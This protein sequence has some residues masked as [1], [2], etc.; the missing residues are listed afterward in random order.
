M[1]LGK[2]IPG[3]MVS[4]E[5]ED[6]LHRSIQ[7]DKH[8]YLFWL[9]YV[10]CHRYR[11]SLHVLIAL[12]K[13]GR[14]G[15]RDQSVVVDIWNRNRRDLT[16]GNIRLISGKANAF[17]NPRTDHCGVSW[18]SHKKKWRTRV[19]M[20]GRTVYLGHYE[21]EPDAWA[22]VDSF[23]DT[24]EFRHWLK[25]LFTDLGMVDSPEHGKNSGE[26]MFTESQ[27]LGARTG[28]L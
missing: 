6:L 26:L 17:N 22:A 27:A 20:D 19:T 10:D 4:P 12:R 18:D 5:D 28:I 24:F 8:D 11:L 13:Y 7:I 3:F 23:K 2:D 1:P 14:A 21:N 15:K 9:W 25:T 16:R